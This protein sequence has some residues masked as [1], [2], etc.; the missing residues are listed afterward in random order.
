[1]LAQGRKA[2]EEQNLGED[3]VSFA[4][5]D[6]FEPQTYQGAS[7]F[8]LRQCTH[9]WHDKDVVRMFSAL[10]PG[11]EAS[12]PDTPLLINEV[13]LAGLGEVPRHWERD[14]RQ[15]DMIMFV[16]TGAKERTADEFAALL[17]EADSRFKISKVHNKGGL[18]LLEV[19][20]RK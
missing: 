16:T 13:V 17:K 1:M 20:L 5:A 15:R 18:S 8:L 2:A 10:V 6:F 12:E 14:M 9:N 4:K 3:R 19:Y 7:A 11:L